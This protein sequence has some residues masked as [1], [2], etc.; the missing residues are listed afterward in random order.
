[1]EG[2][3]ACTRTYLWRLGTSVERLPVML[4]A[5]KAINPWMHFEYLP[6]EGEMRNGRQVFGRAF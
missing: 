5:M 1:M 4:N 6:K 3:A 2:K